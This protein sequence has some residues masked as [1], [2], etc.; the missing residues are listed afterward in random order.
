MSTILFCLSKIAWATVTKYS[1]VRIDHFAAR[2]II[3]QRRDKTH[4]LLGITLRAVSFAQF[5]GFPPRAAH[6]YE[7]T[8]R[9][10]KPSVCL[11]RKED[12]GSL[13]RLLENLAQCCMHA[14]KQERQILFGGADLFVSQRGECFCKRKQR[15]QKFGFPSKLSCILWTVSDIPSCTVAKLGI[16]RTARIIFFCE[17]NPLV[18]V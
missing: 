2:N 14:A 7:Y 13:G 5:W 15:Q 3:E 17:N 12:S 18:I 9:T 6:L 8:S 1:C 16:F 11:I 4:T 10:A